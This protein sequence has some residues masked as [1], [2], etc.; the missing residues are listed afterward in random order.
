MEPKRLAKI[1]GGAVLALVVVLVL[2]ALL[3]VIG[4]P[5]AGIEDNS[6]GDVG[7]ERI[8]ILTTVWIDNPNPFGFSADTDIEYDIELAD[9]HI[10]EGN[11]DNVTVP[12]G[13][14]TE[15]FTT[16][17]QYE[18]IQPWW[19]RHVNNNETSTATVE[20]T[21]NTGVGP[22]SGSPTGSYEREI[23]TDI[24]GALDSG[25]SEFEGTYT[26]SDS[27]ITLPGGTAVE[28]TVEVENVSTAWGEVTENR[29]EILVTTRIN[30]P[31]A[32]PIPIP[33][34][35]GS[36]EFNDVA[37]A[38]WDAD[39]VVLEDA[40]DDA[41]IPPGETEERTFLIELDNGKLPDWFATHVENDEYTRVV[42]SG[43]LALLI[44]DYEVTIPPGSEGLACE[45][46]LT[47]SIFVAQDDG[48]SPGGCAEATLETSQSELES[49]G[50]TVDLTETDWWA[51]LDED[52]D[53]LSARTGVVAP[54]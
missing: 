31:N 6:W 11:I 27:D 2:L 32:Y 34:F 16:D 15:S 40:A 18:Q 35:T 25:F 46:D 48:M 52:D 49:A 28:P 12:A 5:D 10:G 13:R 36:I 33:S 29:S 14:S 8:E 30:N 4:V 24:E 3:G 45:F 47:T 41:L 50:A 23:D 17:M 7:E 38:D 51:S 43:K 37:L 9:V 54:G 22:F 20:A 39:E 44:N 19:N 21:V 42:V 53:T 1:V 26:A